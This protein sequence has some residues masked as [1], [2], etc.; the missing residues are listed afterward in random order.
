M[1]FKS[2]VVKVEEYIQREM[3]DR[4]YRVVFVK[5]KGCPESHM[6][7]LNRYIDVPD[8]RRGSKI[9]LEFQVFN[10]GAIPHLKVIGVELPE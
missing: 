9:I 3:H 4:T 1:R 7:T 2:S 6:F 5:E 10:R 8:I